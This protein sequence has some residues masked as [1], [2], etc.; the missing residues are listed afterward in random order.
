MIT[1]L[2]PEGTVA[3]FEVADATVT[4][5]TA[6]LLTVPPVVFTCTGLF[7]VFTRVN[8]ETQTV[9]GKLII[10]LLRSNSF[11]DNAFPITHTFVQGVFVRTHGVFQTYIISPF[12]RFVSCLDIPPQS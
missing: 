1:T 7:V 2:C 11:E 8:G 9:I 10:F 6:I 4:Q 3:R 5:S 12:V